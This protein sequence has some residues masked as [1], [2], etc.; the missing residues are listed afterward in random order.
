MDSGKAIAALPTN[1]GDPLDYLEVVGRA[2][3]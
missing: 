3:R 1:G 2:S